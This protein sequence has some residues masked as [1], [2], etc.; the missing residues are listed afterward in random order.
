MIKFKNREQIQNL[1]VGKVCLKLKNKGFKPY[2]SEG[3]FNE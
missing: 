2:I 3:L 1:I